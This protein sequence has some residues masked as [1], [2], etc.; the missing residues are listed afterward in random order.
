MATPPRQ[1]L[2]KAKQGWGCG[3]AGR[4][5][6]RQYLPK[7]KRLGT[8]RRCPFLNTAGDVAQW[9]PRTRETRPPFRPSGFSRTVSPLNPS[10]EAFSLVSRVSRGSVSHGSVPGSPSNSHRDIPSLNVTVRKVRSRAG[11]VPHAG[12]PQVLSP[13]FQGTARPPPP[14]QSRGFS[15]LSQ[16]PLRGGGIMANFRS[17][18]F[19]LNM[20]G[21][22][23]VPPHSLAFRPECYPR[24]LHPT[25][26]YRPLPRQVGGQGGSAAPRGYPPSGALQHAVPRPRRVQNRAGRPPASN[27]HSP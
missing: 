27:P 19:F 23:L 21:T 8:P 18:I 10:W 17:R 15:P 1:S 2:P 26:T 14:I 25:Q 11:Q 5:P 24:V 9:G 16:R 12:F 6:I 22:R 3:S 4:C 13:K 7:A 20:A